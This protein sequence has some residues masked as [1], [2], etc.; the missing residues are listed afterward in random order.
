MNFFNV[1]SISAMNMKRLPVFPSIMVTQAME[2]MSKKENRTR[3]DGKMRNRCGS[4]ETV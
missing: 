3:R 2:T 1:T 4:S